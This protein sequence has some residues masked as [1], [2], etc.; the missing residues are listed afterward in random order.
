M[1]DH[2][3]PRIVETKKHLS[4]LRLVSLL[5]P[6]KFMMMNSSSPSLE[7][8]VIPAVLREAGAPL[9]FKLVGKQQA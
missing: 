5:L 1:V 8:S 2:F 9:C 7:S 3:A 4:E 6:E